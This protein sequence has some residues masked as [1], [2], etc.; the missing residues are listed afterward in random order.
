MSRASARLL[1]WSLEK[2]AQTCWTPQ[3]QEVSPH[4]HLPSRAIVTS[5]CLTYD[6]QVLLEQRTAPSPSWLEVTRLPSTAR[7][8]FCSP[9]LARSLTVAISGLDLRRRYLISKIDDTMIPTFICISREKSKKRQDSTNQL[10]LFARAPSQ[11]STWNH[12]A[13]SKVRVIRISLILC[14]EANAV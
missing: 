8:R 5:L 2:L 10:A 4:C 7:S 3:C 9:W 13:W 11:P 12:Y 14:R 1:P 6:L